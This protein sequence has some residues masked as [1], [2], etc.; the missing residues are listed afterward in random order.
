MFR[1]ERVLP[2]VRPK[3]KNESQWLENSRIKLELFNNFNTL[4]VFG[5]LDTEYLR[6][7]G[8]SFNH[9]WKTGRISMP[10]PIF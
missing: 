8:Y 6:T 4:H 2:L 3:V 9:N 5:I 1:F 10:F 7:R